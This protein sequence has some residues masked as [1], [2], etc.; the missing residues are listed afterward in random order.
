M[1]ITAFSIRRP[2]TTGMFFLALLVLGFISASKMPM[3]LFPQVTYPAIS[4]QTSYSGAGPEEIER[5]ITIPVEQAVSTV[6]LVKSITSDSQEGSSRVRVNFSWGMD[7]DEAANDIRANLDRI[8]N[9]LPEDASAPVVFKYDPSMSPVL[10]LSLSGRMD[11]GALRQLAEDEISY[12]LQRVDGV[13]RVEVRGGKVRE[14]G[15]TLKQ[16]RLQSLNITGEQIVNVL[17]NENSMQPAGHLVVGVGEFLLRTKGEFQELNEIRNLIVAQRDGVPVYLKDVAEVKDAFQEVRSLVRIDGKPGIVLSVAKRSGSNTIA[18]ADRLY[19]ALDEVKRLHPELSIRILN[20]DSSYIRKAVGSVME[21]AWLGGLLAGLILLF[22]FHNIRATL[23]AAVAMPT[24]IMTTLILAYFCNMTLNTISLGGLALGVGMLVDNA[25]VVLDNIFRHY[26]V[27]GGDIKRA[28]LE[29]TAEMGPAITASTLTHICVFLPLIYLTGRNG[30]IFRDLSYMVLFSILCSLMVAVTLIPVLCAKFLKV[31]DLDDETIPGIQGFLAKMQHGWEDSYEKTLSWCLKHKKTVFGA[32]FLVFVGTAML[33]PFIGTELIQQTDEGVVQVT[34]QMP[35]GTKLAETDVNA[36]NLE[37]VI[38][39]T[40][41]NELENMEVSVGGRYGGG[42]SPNQAYLT[43]RLKDKK[44]RIRS[45]D[46]IIKSLQEKL[47]I[48]GSR[49]RITAPSSM[50]FLYGGSQ[51]PIQIDIRGYDQKQTRQMAATVMEMIEPIPGIANT[52]M[53][54]EEERPELAISINRK[55]AADYGVT[56]AQIATAV[57]L[58]MEGKVATVY[59]KD[60]QEV[61]IRVNLQESDRRSWQDLSRIMVSGSNGRVISLGSL[62][63]LNQTNSPVNI[64]RKDQERNITVSA[65]LSGRDLSAV[66]QDIQKI[67]AGLTLPDGI[68]IHYAGDY[69]E[70]QQSFAEFVIA[71]I[72][73][74]MLV[75][76]VMAA[77]FESFFDPFVIM[78]SIP[79][80]LGGVLIILLLTNTAFN[81]QVYIGMIMLGGIVVNNAIVL[82]SYVRLMMDRGVPLTEAVLKGS[83]ARLRPVIVTTS[84]TILGLLPLAIGIGEGGET[85]APLARTVIGGLLFSTVLT[86]VIIPVFFAGL[87]SGLKRMKQ[88]FFRTKTVAKTVCLLLLLAVVGIWPQT[89]MAEPV[90][91][92][93]VADAVN[94]ALQNSEESKIIQ[95]KRAKAESEYRGT[96]G[97]KG[98]KVYSALDNETGE[99]Y[100][101]KLG[102]NVEKSIPFDNLLGMKSFSDQI[103]EHNLKITFLDTQYQEQQLVYT[104]IEAFHKELQAKRVMELALITSERSNKLYDEVMVRSKLGLTTVTEELD[105]EAK[106]AVALTDLNRYRQLY[107]LAQIKFRQ[108]LNFSDTIAYELVPPLSNTP[109]YTL[110]GLLNEGQTDRTDIK[111]QKISLE[112]AEVL[113][114]LALL[115]QKYGLSLGWTLERDHYQA[116]VSLTNVDGTGTPGEWKVTGNA[117]ALPVNING[118]EKSTT[119]LTLRWT[120]LDGDVRKERVKQAELL[121]EQYREEIKKTSENAAY[122]IEEAYL[123][124]LNIVDRLSTGEL[125]LRYNRT[126]YD[127]VLTKLRVGLSN[128]KDVLEAHELLSKAEVEL[129]K[130]K[131]D[132]YLAKIKLLL[133]TGRLLPGQTNY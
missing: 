10:T 49:I 11:E 32:A 113:Y 67:L 91:K 52:N 51:Y 103:A 132:L 54:R 124:Y 37:R 95:K 126:N 104:I 98:I 47:R 72:L 50:R 63:D 125:Q 14:I 43:L 19:K 110:N 71:I 121:V 42:G 122:E 25:V 88:M 57:Q 99:K 13:A 90:T 92:L 74:L 128:I 97:A 116:G 70:Q 101:T 28:A 130:V 89:G 41:P 133:V 45:I 86:L 55:R 107:R 36:E 68:T 53:S 114:K 112:R 7:L 6:N 127:S 38:R 85:Q 39:Q 64:E 78:L 29:G 40:I 35:T 56:A 33:F 76:M 21:A 27:N 73:S 109:T 46:T 79:F 82:I 123:N 26:H 94:M 48:P 93:T 2:V 8:K 62:V 3:D 75:Y 119:R 16:E 30:I 96:L 60:G 129:E 81:S 31:R 77:Q 9:R 66:M 34:L 61:Q 5:L 65:S 12:Q 100:T 118:S 20:D 131:T 18:V 105:A 108:L 102:V 17:K 115:S 44:D 69:E 117:G 120:F 111:Q 4:V 15:V 22:F 80:S 23:I 87:E 1:K 24:S 83:R 84:T 58:N 106:Q 59:R